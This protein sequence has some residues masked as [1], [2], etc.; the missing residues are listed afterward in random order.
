[1]I[2]FTV[3]PY[4]P[5]LKSDWDSFIEKAK[6]STFL[7]RRD[8]ME[9]HQ[10]RFD[11][12]SLMLFKKDKVVAVFPANKVG[13]TIY[14]HQGL[15]YGGLL[16]NS[17]LK[18]HTILECFKSVLR[19][20]DKEGMQNL[21]IKIIPA[22]Y[23]AIPSDEVLYIMSILN[24]KLIRRDLLSVV[25]QPSVLK[26]SKDRIDGIKRAK[27]SGLSIKMDDDFDAF[28]NRILIPNLQNK[29]GVNPVHSLDEI[30]LLKERFPNN[31]MQYNVYDTDKIVAGTTIF[32]SKQVA[33]SQ[34][35]SADENK[36]VSGSLDFL[37][38]HLLKEVFSDK[39]YF[40]FGISNE[41]NG[42]NINSGLQYWKEGFGARG[43]VQ[44][45]YQLEI[46][47]YKKLDNV[48]L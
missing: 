29:H 33:H 18:F 42:L 35:I 41:N 43:V 22:I 3:K 1:L 30:K 13:G 34:Y 47:N 26:Y 2:S 31:I 19:F 11:D 40:D 4:N 39:A 5:N 36:N 7:F 16:V 14:S 24:A 12:A 6:N 45:F 20:Y 10:D 8:F 37:H 44:D 23:N 9:Y 32:I 25:K 15:T 46:S 38:D 48:L 21:E 28:W 27:K 17:K